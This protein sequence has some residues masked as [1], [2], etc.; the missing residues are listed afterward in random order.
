MTLLL[1]FQ[2][3][4]LVNKNMVIFCIEMTYRLRKA[5]HVHENP[6]VYMYVDEYVEYHGMKRWVM[7]NLNDRI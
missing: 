7:V 1:L 3:W 2:R 6:L 5:L 4:I